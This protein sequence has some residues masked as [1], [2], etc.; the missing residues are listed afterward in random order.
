MYIGSFDD[1]YVEGCCW[2][3]GDGAF[4]RSTEGTESESGIN[5]EESIPSITDK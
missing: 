4:K 3:P 5:N 1:R 2:M